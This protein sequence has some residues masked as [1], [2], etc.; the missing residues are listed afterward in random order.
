MKKDDVLAKLRAFPV[1]PSGYWVVA[2]AAMVLY[3]IKEE[4]ADIDLGCTQ[5]TA[6]RL[7]ADGY[8]YRKTRDGRRWFRIGGDIEIFEGWLF[9]RVVSVEGVPVISIQGLIE[10]KRDLGRDKDLRDLERIERYLAART[11]EPEKTKGRNA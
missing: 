1:D 10:L 7:E 11:D 5:K 9:D 2:G 8:L 6:D 3:G 4:T